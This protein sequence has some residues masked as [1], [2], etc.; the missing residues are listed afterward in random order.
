MHKTMGAVPSMYTDTHRH[1]QTLRRW[2]QEAQKF[3][4]HK[5]LYRKLGALS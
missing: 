4:N 1:T 5:Q 3:K 2:S